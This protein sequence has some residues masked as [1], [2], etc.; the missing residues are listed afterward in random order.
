MQLLK[1]LHSEFL[2]LR[3]MAA[4]NLS[5]KICAQT[6]SHL[7]LYTLQQGNGG[8]VGDGVGPEGDGACVCH[9]VHMYM[10][11]AQWEG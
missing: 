4:W 11:V 6:L 7:S 9:S 1:S 2:I 3:S 5:V 8:G 10:H